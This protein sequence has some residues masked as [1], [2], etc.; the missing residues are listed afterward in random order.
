MS[1]PESPDVERLRAA[2]ASLADQPDWPEVSE[3]EAARM[4]EALHGN[5]SS[6]ERREVIEELVRN[7]RA[8]QAWRLANELPVTAP[9]SVARRWIVWACAA[10]AAVTL[11]I[12][13]VTGRS[14]QWWDVQTPGYRSLEPRTIASLVPADAPLPRARPVLRW[15]P[16]DGARYRLRVLTADLDLLE[17]RENLAV[18]EYQLSPEVLR[19]VPPGGRIVWQVEAKVP[20]T[21]PLVS[22]TFSIRLE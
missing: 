14:L 15:T 5:L 17:E 12:V 13:G 22:P 20:D 18:P 8:A 21:A 16:V 10:A 6:E 1:A 11:V 19:R 9:P 2:L 7:P 4:F 3:E